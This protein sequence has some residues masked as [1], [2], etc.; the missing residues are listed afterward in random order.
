MNDKKEAAI[1]GVVIA[2]AAVALW[3]L[4]RRFFFHLSDEE[5]ATIAAMRARKAEEV[6][7]ARAES[8]SSDDTQEAI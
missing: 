5:I 7:T 2:F 4:G 8:K 3:E 1:A 6:A